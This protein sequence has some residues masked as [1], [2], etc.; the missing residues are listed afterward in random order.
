LWRNS[1]HFLS[2]ATCKHI[3]C[4]HNHEKSGL[5][6]KCPVR[7]CAVSICDRHRDSIQLP[8]AVVEVGICPMLS[9]WV[10]LDVYQ[11]ISNFGKIPVA[12]SAY[13]SSTCHDWGLGH[14]YHVGKNS[15]CT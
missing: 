9:Y 7:A 13:G 11:G 5:Q 8:H 3:T 15:S 10:T 2:V 12:I 1:R 6:T 4:S 14:D